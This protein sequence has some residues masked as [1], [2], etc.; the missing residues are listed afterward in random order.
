MFSSSLTFDQ[1]VAAAINLSNKLCCTNSP[2]GGQCHGFS[3]A[4][5]FQVKMLSEVAKLMNRILHSKTHF[6]SS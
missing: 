6:W 5:P 1:E 4:L 3:P 2:H